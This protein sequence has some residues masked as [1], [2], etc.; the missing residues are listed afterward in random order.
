LIDAGMSV[1]RFNLSHGT[2]KVTNFS[3]HL[4]FVGKC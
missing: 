3:S 2:V 1:A 4:L